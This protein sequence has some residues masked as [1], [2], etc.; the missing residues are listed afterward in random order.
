MREDLADDLAGLH[1]EERRRLERFADAFDRVNARDYPLYA[2]AAASEGV[3]E[4]QQRA[5]ELIG[6]GERKRAVRAAIA[7][8]VDAGTQAYARG[9]S[10]TDTF[11]LFQPVP[12]RAED[13]VR[14]LRTVERAVVGLILWDDLEPDDRAALI[15]PWGAF[16][17]P[18]K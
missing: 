16:I 14:F 3:K 10:L 12:D 11:L 6:G 4:A 17:Q 18:P 5:R 1:P 8:F 9:M 2:E 7:A 13:R 15:G